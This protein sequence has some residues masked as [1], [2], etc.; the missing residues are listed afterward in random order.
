MIL[1]D[2]KIK[3]E[4]LH[5]LDRLIRDIIINVYLKHGDTEN[6]R[7][8][9]ETLSNRIFKIA[10][11]IHNGEQI[12]L[13]DLE[14]LDESYRVRQPSGNVEW[15]AFPPATPTNNFEFD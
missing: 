4:V 11:Q 12:E 1:S 9:I 8:V 6:S 7:T 5:K 10:W 13:V 3:D 15:K 2:S 14:F